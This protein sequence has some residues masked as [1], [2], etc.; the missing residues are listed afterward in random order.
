MPVLF[1]S[2]YTDAFVNQ[3]GLLQQDVILLAK[4]VLLDQLSLKLRQVLD[5]ARI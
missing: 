5:S 4:P 3:R 2:G 1:M